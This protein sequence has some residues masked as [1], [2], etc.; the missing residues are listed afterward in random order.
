MNLGDMVTHK[1]TG[2]HIYTV[3]KIN[4]NIVTVNRPK[5]LWVVYNMRFVV[6]E[7]ICMIQNLKKI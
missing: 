7:S 3:K 2:D 1:N 4:G 6:K 5:E